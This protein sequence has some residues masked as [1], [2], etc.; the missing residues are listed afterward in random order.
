[1]FIKKQKF[2]DLKKE[3]SDATKEKECQ[4][5]EIENLQKVI[6]KLEKINNEQENELN[7]YR[8]SNGDE[9]LCYSIS[10]I[11]T[12][13]YQNKFK[14]AEDLNWNNHYLNQLGHDSEIYLD[15]IFDIIYMLDNRKNQ[16]IS[17]KKLIMNEFLT[18]DTKKFINSDEFKFKFENN[19]E[20]I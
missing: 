10:S 4:L 2:M 15:A 19:K 18:D 6:K 14:N 3:L 11:G 17:I 20:S 8:K 1:M 9:D 7:S 12:K 13:K 5:K 16:K